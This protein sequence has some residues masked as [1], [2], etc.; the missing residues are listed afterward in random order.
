MVERQ[1]VR[2]RKVSFSAG[3]FGHIVVKMGSANLSQISAK[4]RQYNKDLILFFLDV[5]GL[6]A[7]DV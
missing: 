7:A 1:R 4:Y 3:Q 2:L 6:T 5:E